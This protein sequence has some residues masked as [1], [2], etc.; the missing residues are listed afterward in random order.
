MWF[1]GFWVLNRANNFTTWRLEQGVLL[2]RKPFCVYVLSK[3][4]KMGRNKWFTF[5]SRTEIWKFLNWYHW[6]IFFWKKTCWSPT[7]FFQ[8]P[9]QVYWIVLNTSTKIVSEGGVIK[10]DFFETSKNWGQPRIPPFKGRKRYPSPHPLSVPFWSNSSIQETSPF[11]GHKLW[12]QNKK[13]YSLCISYLQTIRT[14]RN[15]TLCKTL[16]MSNVGSS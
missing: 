7:R 3:S 13:S 5:D 16:K 14:T 9:I 1:S 12:F 11:K 15:A 8:S 6:I 4:V 2:D 10:R